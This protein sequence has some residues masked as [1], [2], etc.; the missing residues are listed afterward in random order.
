[1]LGEVELAIHLLALAQYVLWPDCPHWAALST[2]GVL[3]SCSAMSP[4][5]FPPPPP[6]RPRGQHLGQLTDAG[7]GT[8]LNITLRLAVGG[9]P[10]SFQCCPMSTIH[11][12]LFSGS[13]RSF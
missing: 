4:R 1:M 2:T 12:V 9:A 10:L 11:D 13:R 3:G 7:A 8:V 5:S 6:P